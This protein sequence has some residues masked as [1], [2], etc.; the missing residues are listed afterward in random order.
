MQYNWFLSHC[1]QLLQWANI[2]PG[3]LSVFPCRPRLSD[4]TWSCH[5]FNSSECQ[6]GVVELT[7]LKGTRCQL[8]DPHT[9]R[10]SLSPVRHT[11]HL[12]MPMTKN[13]LWF[14]SM[15]PC[16]LQQ[17]VTVTTSSV[18]HHFALCAMPTLALDSSVKPTGGIP[19]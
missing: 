16:L 7:F 8:A 3:L 11:L 13:V 2:H 12:A 1:E 14:Q 4:A 9:H 19:G 5:P 17:D 15:L 6:D 18:T 10:S